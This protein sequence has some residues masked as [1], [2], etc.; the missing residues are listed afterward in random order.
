MRAF[1]VGGWIILAGALAMSPLA[2]AT[3]GLDSLRGAVQGAQR[4]ARERG[5]QGVAVV[6]LEGDTASQDSGML[7]G[8]SQT[9]RFAFRRYTLIELRPGH[10]G[11]YS[12]RYVRGACTGIA[13]CRHNAMLD[14]SFPADQ[15]R[16][17]EGGPATVPVLLVFQ[18]LDRRPAGISYGLSREQE[19]LRFAE[20]VEHATSAKPYV[21]Y[22][23]VVLED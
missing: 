16:S 23:D 22:G 18:G 7:L 1:A 13:P 20:G 6:V 5:K 2:H 4:S 19:F 10:S 15:V 21:S 3:S 17:L 14:K 11:Q 9:L 8:H 12:A